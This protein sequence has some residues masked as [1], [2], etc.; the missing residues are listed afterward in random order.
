MIVA[1]LHVK[2]VPALR[3][4]PEDLRTRWDAELLKSTGGDEVDWLCRISQGVLLRWRYEEK[5]KALPFYGGD[6]TA[7]S[8][9]L[10]NQPIV[11]RRPG[12]SHL[13]ATTVALALLVIGCGRGDGSFVG[14]AVTS[15]RLDS[16]PSL[17][18]YVLVDAEQSGRQSRASLTLQFLGQRAYA[19]LGSAAVDSLDR[20][21]RAALADSATLSPGQSRT[22]EVTAGGVTI[23]KL[24]KAPPVDPSAAWP[25]AK[26]GPVG[27]TWMVTVDGVTDLF[28]P[29]RVGQTVAA[30]RKAWP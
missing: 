25:M 12:L 4:P 13:K 27:S 15:T 20:F 28:T 8:V 7:A 5:P 18:G 21:T 10:A 9:T 6:V 29:S 23:T 2:G 24:S 11:K 30:L 14:E 1:A 16:I 17:G 26:P 19:T 3:P 22:L